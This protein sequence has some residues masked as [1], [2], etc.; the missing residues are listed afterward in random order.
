MQEDKSLFSGDHVLGWGTTFIFD[1]YDYMTTLQFMIALRPVHLFPG[2][3]PMI[4]DG[5]GLLERYIGHRKE[6]EDQVEDVLLQR[7][8]PVSIPDVVHTL[9]TNT[10][11]ERLWMAQ[12]NVQKILRKFDKGGIALSFMRQADGTLERYSFARNW[13]A[14]R[15]LPENL[16][17]LHRFHFR[18]ETREEDALP[19]PLGL[20]S[21]A[22]PVRQARL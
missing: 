22:A 4:E 9:Y 15:R 6:R 5:V 2:H 18:A 12:E 20:V 10:P 13:M 17:W 16:V 11:P 14:M 3:G 7:P 19:S 1:L 8:D 21:E